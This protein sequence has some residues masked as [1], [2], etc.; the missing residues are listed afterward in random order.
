M[1]TTRSTSPAR[2]RALL[3]AAAV[4]VLAA[5]APEG[6]SSPDVAATVNGEEIPLSDV[7]VRFE[8]VRENPQF[9]EQI[10]ADDDGEFED[11]VQAEILTGL[12]RARLLAQGADELG[13]EL[14]EEDVEAKREEV[15]EQVGGDDAFAEVVEANNLTE[16]T[17]DSQLRDLALQDL[18][19]EELS[20]D[21][22]VDEEDVQ[23][24]YDQT[25]G[26]ASARHILVET[27]E[28][29]Q[30]VL[31]RLGAG[32]DF[33]TLAQE[34]STDPSA[35]QNAGDLGEF[36]RGQM[37]PEFTEAVFAAEAGETIGPVQTDFGY[38]IIEV[39]EVDQG[40]PL[41]EVE[42]EI[43]DQLL[44]GDRGEALQ[45]WLD[46]LT[47]EAEISVNPRFGEWDPEAGQVVPADALGEDGE[48]DGEGAEGDGEG[49]EEDG[50][51][52]D[53]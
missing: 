24:Q 9:A 8:A 14:S 22:E 52:A 5:C 49:A 39:V 29:A 41:T 43:R 21:L 27:E 28:E 32:E 7:Q 10:A 53:S 47:Q 11:Q 23:E 37:V 33:G 6:A 2:L 12:I 34:L 15:I 1:R 25:Y 13:L 38:H 48:E 40:P 35:E 16:E 4:A 42:D 36:T 26:T 20:A 30:A 45:E 31:E 51:G 18:V 44:E 19:A 46:E 50:E 3:L 17:V